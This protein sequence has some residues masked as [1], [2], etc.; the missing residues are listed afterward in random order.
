MSAPI[1]EKDRN[2][3]PE[4]ARLRRPDETT[5]LVERHSLPAGWRVSAWEVKNDRTP[6]EFIEVKGA[7]YPPITRGKRKGLPNYRKPEPGTEMRL[8]FTLEDITAWCAEWERETGLCSAC[9]GTG[10]AWNGWHHERGNHF[11]VCSACDGSGQAPAAR[12]A[13]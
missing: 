4:A 8:S 10:H 9:E 3:V 1:Y 2:P 5:F 11:R 13:A 12:A 7:V 6:Q